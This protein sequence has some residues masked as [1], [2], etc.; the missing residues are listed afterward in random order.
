[1]KNRYLIIVLFLFH[2]SDGFGGIPHYWVGGTGNWS[3]ITHWSTTS[4]GPGNCTLVPSP[5][6]SVIFDAASF[7]AGGQTVTIIGDAVCKD[8]I[9][10]GAGNNPTF[11]GSNSYTLRICGSL[12]L[13]PSMSFSFQG[14]VNFEATNPGNT[15][16]T[17]GKTFAQS[18][19]FN[20]VGGGWTLLSHL[21]VPNDIVYLE[22]GSLNTN[23]KTLTCLEFLSEYTSARSLA[24]GTSTLV[25]TNNM[26]VNSTNLILNCGTSLIKL[27]SVDSRLMAGSGLTYYRVL[28]NESTGISLSM[29]GN[30]TF[31]SVRFNGGGTISGNHT[32]DTLIFS[33][34]KMY[35]IS[36]NTI[37]TIITDFKLNGT[38]SQQIIITSGLNGT[39]ATFSKTGGSVM[40]NYLVLK[41][42]WASGG[43]NFTANNSVDQGNNIGWTI[44]ALASPNLYWV[45]NGGNWDDVN[46]WSTTSGGPGGACVPSSIHN[47]IFDD[48]SFSLPNQVVT[49]N[50][51]N[52]L[53]NDMNW[54]GV[55]YVPK[56][57]GPGTSCLRIYG[58]LAFDPGMTYNFAGRVFFQAINTGK[59]VKSCN[60]VFINSVW[61]FGING[62]W[63]LED[64]FNV[65]ND[66]IRL[67]AGELNTNYS[68]V[69]CKNL[70]CKTSLPFKLYLTNSIINIKNL[71]IFF[72]S[73]LV[74]FCGT[75]T[76]NLTAKNAYAEVGSLTYYRMVFT[77]TDISG[78]VT[79]HHL[80]SHFTSLAFYG[81]EYQWIAC[82]GCNYINYVDTLIL[83]PGFHYCFFTE[84]RINHVLIANGT[85]NKRIFISGGYGGK[86]S[87]TSDSISCNYLILNHFPATGGAT[88]IANNS[89]DLENNAGWIINALLPRNLYWVNGSGNWDE[90][91][92]WDTDSMGVGGACP[93]A[94]I[95]NVFFGGHSFSTTNQ[96]VTLNG[97]YQYCH[98]MTWKV[99]NSFPNLFFL[100]SLQKTLIYGSLRLDP[101]MSFSY[102]PCEFQFW[103]NHAGNTIYSAGKIFNNI[104]FNGQNGEYSLL[105]DIMGA[106]TIDVNGGVLNTNSKSIISE[107]IAG[108]Y[109][110]LNLGNSTITCGFLF[111]YTDISFNCGTSLINICHSAAL[112]EDFSADNKYFNRIRFTNL[113]QSIVQTMI[114]SNNTFNS[115]EFLGNGSIS[116]PNHYDTLTFSPGKTY[117]LKSSTLQTINNQL[118]VR[119]NNCFP[120][121]IKSSQLG[122]L[123]TFTKSTGN[124]TGDFLELKDIQATGGATFYAGLHST[125]MGNNP[126]WNWGDAP[127]YSFG[128][129]ADTSFCEG[130]TLLLSTNNFN[131]GIS[132][133]WGDGSTT[134]TQKVTQAGTYKVKVTYSTNCYLNDSVN[135]TVKPKPKLHAISDQ[136]ICSG[137]NTIQVNFTS[138]LAGTSYSW[139]NSLPSIGLPLRE[140]EMSLPS[141]RITRVIYP[142]LLLSQSLL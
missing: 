13:I 36:Q 32:F 81:N 73:A 139:T 80:T 105:D 75:S 79:F 1:M 124:V 52:A 99:Q 86:I 42:I 62:Q 78:N 93:P 95:D 103:S 35:Q 111:L 64:N 107:R 51:D 119:G 57:E 11:T 102:S 24:L 59:K 43:A 68:N 132:W 108:N 37:Q 112:N 131:G 126:G 76:I 22:N 53:C 61:F 28:F 72:P 122:S 121:V 50:I 91:S 141:R 49:I 97:L 140:P 118:N 19:R 63:S 71:L 138:T 25:I 98:D 9:W 29:E 66:S 16:N 106:W 40:G 33:P 55:T 114:G 142:I 39:K 129:G 6:D 101:S 116:G 130:D 34:G 47:V 117:T 31:K 23:G 41:D 109:G 125:N 113:N 12:T 20:G 65:S 8:M 128:L 136:S 46:H 44:N 5:Q 135:V 94:P 67:E 127:G 77:S 3:E 54:T 90:P 137:H 56:F 74:L 134:P 89:I 88:F 26:K 17:A 48:S 30:S 21:T 58:S 70:I 85:C 115:V 15:I 45:G 84:Q 10:T 7:G 120:I 60:K 100:G 92:H 123:A 69:N 27:L 14:K 82:T 87:K 83:S 38:C 110:I 18:V 2:V 4:G 104:S 96:T 133:L